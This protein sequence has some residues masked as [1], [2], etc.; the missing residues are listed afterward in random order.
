M[1]RT[2]RCENLSAR[3][4]L[5]LLGILTSACAIPAA[6]CTPNSIWDTAS[7]LSGQ[8]EDCN[9]NGIPDS[10]EPLEFVRSTVSYPAGGGTSLQ[11]YDMDGDQ[12]LDMVIASGTT[13]YSIMVNDGK[14][15]FSQG[16]TIGGF[17]PPNLILGGMAVG[18]FDG[19]GIPDIARGVRNCISFFK[20]MGSLTFAPAGDHIVPG[21]WILIAGDMDGDQD[22]DLVLADPD[23]QEI[24]VV[25]NNGDGGFK[26]SQKTPFSLKYPFAMAMADLDHDG[27]QDIV[28]ANNYANN[29]SV[30]LN[31]GRA[32]L[33]TGGIAGALNRPFAVATGD[34]DGDGNADI[35]CVNG[36]GAW[37]FANNGSARFNKLTMVPIRVPP[38]GVKL[39]DLNGDGS[40]DIIVTLNQDSNK[41][42]PPVILLN[43]NS[44]SF[45][46]LP[47]PGQF[48]GYNFRAGD[49]DGDG[50]VDLVSFNSNSNLNSD[51]EVVM[52]MNKPFECIPRSTIKVPADFATIQAALD[53][54]ATGDVVLVAPGTYSGPGN[55]RLEF[56]GKGILLQSDAGPEKTEIDLKGSPGFLFSSGEG[57]SAVLS[58]FYITGGSV[59]V[60]ATGS[61]PVISQCIISGNSVGLA[62]NN[63]SPTVVN[64]LIA[65][66]VGAGCLPSDIGCLGQGGAGIIVN[67]SGLPSLLN[68]TI[69]DNS[70]RAAS[71]IYC[72]Q[73]S[74]A[75]MVNSIVWGNSV[76]CSGL[77]ASYSCIQGGL[78]GEGN[79]SSDPLLTADFHLRPD[80]PAINAGS[81][82]GLPTR[83]LSGAA[84]PCDASIDMGAYETCRGTPFH[85]GDPNNDGTLDIS[86]GIAVFSFLFLGGKAPPCKNSADANSDGAIDISD[87]VFLLNFLFL[88]GPPPAPPGPPGKP[89]GWGTEPAGSSGD[90]G[91]ELYSGCA[92]QP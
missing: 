27:D 65:R 62:S 32:N 18:D 30:L 16:P 25:L 11:L 15:G 45:T 75:E 79:I 37:V 92:S 22:L 88:S 46:P 89:C 51:G 71:G 17:E 40:L 8:E 70:A 68:C 33:R 7:I 84:R 55:Q 4:A 9:A 39:A 10:C 85:R 43:K 81:P 44:G 91:C 2:L 23:A 56:H 20:N 31:D 86:D 13:L 36:E 82:K 66:N 80:S 47:V 78:N 12:D 77:G 74:V 14:G 49:L 83:D 53:S 72:E 3:V 29:V 60:S 6:E 48:T 38:I 24:S 67:G 1:D 69:A 87:G 26:F 19:D 52:L 61:S 34:L 76:G 63:A 5:A 57:S 90:L 28:V 54:A 35:A 21:G 64:C 58:G 41:S 59:G 73:S 42:R 50:R